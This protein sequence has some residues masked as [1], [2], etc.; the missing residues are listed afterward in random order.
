M[1]EIVT[2]DLSNFGYRELR[3]A[4][5][6]LEAYIDNKQNLDVGD[7]LKLCFNSH[8]GY[9]FLTNEDYRVFMLNNE[10]LEE[11]FNCPI[12]GCE[13]FKEEVSKIENHT[14]EDREC[15]DWIKEVSSR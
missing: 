3:S 4:I 9:V 10:E 1:D 2:A 5:K 12:C 8:S 11:W 6:L 7:G 15:K 14:D 13:G